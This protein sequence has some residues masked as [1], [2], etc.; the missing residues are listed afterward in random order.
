MDAVLYCAVSPVCGL[1]VV[2]GMMVGDGHFFDGLPLYGNLDV[3]QGLHTFSS[4]IPRGMWVS[5]VSGWLAAKEDGVD[6]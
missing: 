3:W 1:A 4:S 5:A 2:G 6:V